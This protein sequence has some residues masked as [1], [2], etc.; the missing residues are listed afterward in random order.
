MNQRKK[1][2]IISLSEQP[3]FCCLKYSLM[4]CNAFGIMLGIFVVLFGI[5]YPD[6]GFPGKL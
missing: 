3:K 6:E 2:S 1:L 4:A 5:S